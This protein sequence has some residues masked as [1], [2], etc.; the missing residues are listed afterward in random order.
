[1]I[2]HTD[3]HSIGNEKISGCKRG[4]STTTVLLRLR[5]GIMKRGELTMA[6]LGTFSNDD[7]NGSENFTQK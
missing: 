6:M 5:D 3:R 1:M 4:H 7:G 2:E